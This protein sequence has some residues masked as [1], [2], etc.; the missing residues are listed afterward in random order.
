MIQQLRFRKG[1]YVR[2]IS[3][4]HVY[5]IKYGPDVCRIEKNNQPAYAYQ[6]VKLY[7]EKVTPEEE[8]IMWVRAAA[9]MEQQFVPAPEICYSSIYGPEYPS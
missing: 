2:H 5:Q 1:S 8:A 9:V 6:R 4:G 3:K 7:M